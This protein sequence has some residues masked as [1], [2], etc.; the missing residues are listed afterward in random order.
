MGRKSASASAVGTPSIT[1]DVAVVRLGEIKARIEQTITTSSLTAE[2][3]D[4]LDFVLERTLREALGENHPDVYRITNTG[5]SFVIDMDQPESRRARER[6]DR[7][8]QIAALIGELLT[9]IQRSIA[10]A[11]PRPASGVQP[12]ALQDVERLVARFHQ[13]ARRIRTRYDHRPTLEIKDEYDV[14]D[15]L[16]ALLS[17]FFNDIRKEE[18]TPSYAGKSSR[19]DFLLKAEQIVVEV[20][21]TRET[22]GEKEVGDQLLIDIARYRV[23]QDCKTLVCFVYDP[24]ER[25]GNPVGLEHDLSGVRD[26]LSVKVFVAPRS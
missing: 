10:D 25:I 14:Q 4:A 22:L 8:K 24:A 3:S 16:H 6:A 2:Q 13:A 20:K 5:Q 12:T 11:P 9:H 1:S 23:H 26:G 18:W 19:M 21:M 7:F 15:L 17:L